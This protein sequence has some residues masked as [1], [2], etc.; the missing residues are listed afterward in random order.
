VSHPRRRRVGRSPWWIHGEEARSRRRQ[1]DR[2]SSGSPADALET[3]HLPRRRHEVFNE[4][5]RGEVLDDVVAF[6]GR[7]LT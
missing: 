5:N 4:T 1:T 2:R 6:V 7:A 3:P